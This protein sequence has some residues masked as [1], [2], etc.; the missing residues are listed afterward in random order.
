[1]HRCSDRR[2]LN[3][4]GVLI[5]DPDVI[6]SRLDALELGRGNAV[7]SN[8][9]SIDLIEYAQSRVKQKLY[10]ARYARQSV[11]DWEDREVSELSEYFAA[12]VKM[13]ENENEMGRMQEDR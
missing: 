6:A 1:M 11:F 13:I 3:G 5:T 8:L 9:I 10:L 7:W 2:W 12:T 4:D